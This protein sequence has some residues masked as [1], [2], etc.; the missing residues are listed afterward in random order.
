MGD[1]LPY[2]TIPYHTIPYLGG[3]FR[4]RSCFLVGVDFSQ[5]CHGICKLAL[6]G[7]EGGLQL[8]QGLLGCL[9]GLSGDVRA[10]ICSRRLW[11]SMCI[12][13]Y[14][15]IA[16]ACNRKESGYIDNDIQSQDSPKAAAILLLLL[17]LFL[18]RGHPHTHI[19]VIYGHIRVIYGCCV[20]HVRMRAGNASRRW[21]AWHGC[22][23]GACW[24]AQHPGGIH[25]SQTCRHPARTE[26]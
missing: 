9:C 15:V 22:L 16:C 26:P 6:G 2:H 17:L 10:D 7:A 1:D 23:C 3:L 4:F 24:H 13:L 25:G 8:R 5:R 14:H 20:Q 12:T 18:A 11:Q 21:M 19:R